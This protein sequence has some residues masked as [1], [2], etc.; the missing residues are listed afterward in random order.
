MTQ[1]T[2]KKMTTTGAEMVSRVME[3]YAE[4]LDAAKTGKS[5]EPIHLKSQSHLAEFIKTYYKTSS[6]AAKEILDEMYYD[7]DISQYYKD[8]IDEVNKI[9]EK[10]NEK[11][12]KS[13]TAKS[14]K[15][16]EEELKISIGVL[17]LLPEN[18]EFT[19]KEFAI[20]NNKTIQKATSL[21]K[22]LVKKEVIEMTS[23]PG[24]TPKTYKLKQSNSYETGAN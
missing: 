7:P 18:Q 17:K 1:T 9:K 8:A 14:T 11:K 15:K 19:T 12:R 10:E 3:M 22:E 13:N 21:L 24:S 4:R 20:A 23:R 6:A 16:K 5:Q 2:D